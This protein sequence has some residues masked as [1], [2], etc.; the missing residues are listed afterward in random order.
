[1]DR[2][3]IRTRRL[4]VALG[5]NV[6]LA[7]VQLGGGLAAHSLGLLSDAGHNVTDVA[8]LAMSLLAVRWATRPRSPSH[9][10]GY[11]RGPIL[12]ALANTAVIAVVTVAIVVESVVRLLHPHPVHGGVVVTVA[13]VAFVTNGLAAVMLR[14]RSGDLNMRSATLH[15]TGDALGSLA[16][17]S[18][19]VVLVADH[20]LEWADPAASLV[21]AAIILVEA[22]RLLRASVDVLL[23][24]SPADVDLAELTAVMGRVPGVAEVHDLHVWSLSSDVRALSAHVVLSGHPTLEQAQIVGDRV[25]SAIGIPFTIAHSTL[26]LECERCIDGEV[27]PCLMDSVADA[28]GASSR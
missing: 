12:A 4:V 23:E 22:Y 26:E 24:S 6:A 16:V 13:A 7:G 8:G 20:A 2:S 21:V 27:D 11:H 19:G 5:L 3:T 14:E 15:M 9:S 25:K 1:M 17:L 10:F 18:A 28:R